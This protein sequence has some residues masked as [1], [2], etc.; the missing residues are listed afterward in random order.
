MVPSHGAGISRVGPSTRHGDRQRTGLESIKQR[1]PVHE[2]ENQRRPRGRVDETVNSGD[3]GM[4]PR[5]EHACLMLE[6]GKPRWI[7]GELRRQHLQRDRSAEGGVVRAVDL[8]HPAGTNGGD[9]LVG[10]D[11]ITRS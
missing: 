1:S 9:D 8:A 10:T 5:R 4:V 3:V 6:T 11:A 7:A 2:L